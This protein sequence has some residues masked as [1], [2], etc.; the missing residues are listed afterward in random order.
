[1]TEDIRSYRKTIGALVGLLTVWLA[2]LA[3][4]AFTT[5]GALIVG[6]V[7]GTLATATLLATVCGLVVVHRAQRVATG[8]GDLF[9]HL[10]GPRVEESFLERE[11][12]PLR[13]LRRLFGA[14]RTLVGDRVRI[15]SLVAIEATLDS[16]RCLDGMP[17]MPE[18]ERFCGQD[19]RV[20]RVVDK[21]YDYGGR[22]DFRRLKGAVLLHGLRCDGAAHDGCQAAC[23]LIWKTA[24]L[25]PAEATSGPEVHGERHPTTPVPT[26]EFTPSENHEAAKKV[27][28]CQYTNLVAASRPMLDWDIRQYVR[29]LL[30]GNLT[31]RA[32][33]A[34][35]ATRFFNAVQA[36]RGGIAYP[37]AQTGNKSV[38]R[39]LHLVPGDV[40]CVRTAAQI[41]ETLNKTG[42][43]KGL[44]FD[45]D[46]L[47]RVGEQ[48]VVRAR[49]KR[50]I[51]DATGEMLTMAAP[52]I[53]LEGVDGSGE[54]MR[55]CAQH[56]YLFWREV[57]LAR[58]DHAGAP[59]GESSPASEQRP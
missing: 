39:E 15:K 20:F 41:A 4:L 21:I 58:I 10:N 40:V 18:M 14:P 13:W 25:E 55:F 56:D 22:K 3:G 24:W 2:V 49:V 7:I 52:C 32:F 51:S 54:F 12:P 5:E 35:M 9:L 48:Y 46:M 36:V 50:I 33:L 57:W 17:F 31:L 45:R 6:L 26:S 44:W 53:L 59:S 43:N 23:Y 38:H 27:Y 28:R 19:A 30:A 1:M 42:R 16:T 47:K 8:R 11:R 37:W 34:T 29:P